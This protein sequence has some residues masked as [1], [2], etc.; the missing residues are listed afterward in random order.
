MIEVEL[1]IPRTDNDG[2]VFTAGEFAAFEAFALELFS[3]VT[4]LPGDVNGLWAEDG[5]TYR[6]TLVAYVV[7]L[8]SI[9]DGHKVGEL[10]AFAVRHFRQE[11]IY[12]RYL[13][14]A[15]IV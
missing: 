10:A 6:D 5:I 15:E 2:V 4:R 9:T 1:F 14:R 12:L 11:A 7:A 13:G 8:P 3:G